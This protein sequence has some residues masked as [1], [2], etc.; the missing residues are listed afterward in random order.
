MLY[1]SCGCLFISY[2]FS[3]SDEYS[4]LVGRANNKD[5]LVIVNAI[6]GERARLLVEALLD[7]G[8]EV[9]FHG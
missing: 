1:D 7:K 9:S 3:D 6:E 4:V 5:E 8:H 2:D